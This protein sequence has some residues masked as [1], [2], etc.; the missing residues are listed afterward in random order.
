MSDVAAVAK[1]QIWSFPTY[2]KAPSTDS[3]QLTKYVFNIQGAGLNWKACKMC[4]HPSVMLLSPGNY[5]SSTSHNSGP[6]PQASR[7]LNLCFQVG[8]SIFW[9]RS[10]LLSWVVCSSLLILSRPLTLL[11]AFQWEL[12][13]QRTLRLTPLHLPPWSPLW[14]L[15][16]FS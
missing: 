4:I 6:F 13:R 5:S 9:D 10:L 11:L 7:S 3:I 15:W 1:L 2:S 8:L 14:G 12:E 16:V